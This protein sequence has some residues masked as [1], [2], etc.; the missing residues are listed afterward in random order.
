MKKLFLSLLLTT[1]LFSGA[2]AEDNAT[3]P[4]CQSSVQQLQE[5]AKA[6]PDVALKLVRDKL[7]V[8]FQEVIGEDL[9]QLGADGMLIAF[10]PGDDSAFVALLKGDCVLVSGTM[11]AAKV[12]TDLENAQ[13]KSDGENF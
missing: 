3:A 1:A 12:K 10:I 8:A 11:S 6:A 4:Q 9:T 2:M 13:K 7:F 5:Q